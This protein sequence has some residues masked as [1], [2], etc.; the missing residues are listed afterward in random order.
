[1][2]VLW[3]AND[4][5]IDLMQMASFE[6]GA[7]VHK[8]APLKSHAISLNIVT[9]RDCTQFQFYLCESNCC[10]SS[11]CEFE[12][13][14]FKLTTHSLTAFKFIAAFRRS[15]QLRNCE[16]ECRFQMPILLTRML[17]KF[18]CLRVK[19]NDGFN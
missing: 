2:S 15:L 7:R 12:K 5:V 1:M 16:M 6:H 10:A 14:Q 4:V 8:N 13:R 11:S 19:L 3:K 18:T 17:H 9:T